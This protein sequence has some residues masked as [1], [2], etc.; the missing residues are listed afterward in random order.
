[1][2]RLT[3]HCPEPPGKHHLLHLRRGRARIEAQVLHRR[4]LS[5]AAREQG[6]KRRPPHG[7]EQ[8]LHQRLRL[9][10]VQAQLRRLQ[11]VEGCAI[12]RRHAES[13][14]LQAGRHI[15]GM[16]QQLLRRN[17]GGKAHRVVRGVVVEEIDLATQRRCACV[18]LLFRK[19]A[20]R[21]VAGGGSRRHQR[22]CQSCPRTSASHAR[23]PAGWHLRRFD[24]RCAISCAKSCLPKLSPATERTLH[25]SRH[26]QGNPVDLHSY[27]RPPFLGI[28]SY[29]ILALARESTANGL[30]ESVGMP[31]RAVSLAQ[32]RY[33]SPE[34]P[35]NSLKTTPIQVVPG[36][37]VEPPRPCD[38]RILSPLRLPV[39][40]SRRISDSTSAG[41][42][43]Q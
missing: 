39:P 36:G 12:F 20:A 34:V 2:E 3:A 31:W 16:I 40:P 30:A 25:S 18:R 4:Q 41:L 42:A 1:M 8:V 23:P 37:G 21:P 15:A 7:I 6:G 22:G 32:M 5:V 26:A 38:R 17:A 9:H 35:Y 13:V 11:L 33:G 27:P 14:H 10:H 29:E 43:A 28:T 24:C 19:Q